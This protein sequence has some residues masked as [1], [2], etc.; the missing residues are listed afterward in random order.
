MQARIVDMQTRIVDMQVGVDIAA[1]QIGIHHSND[2]GIHQRD[3]SRDV[4]KSECTRGY[5]RS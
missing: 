3:S 1:N 5:V 4:T 2:I